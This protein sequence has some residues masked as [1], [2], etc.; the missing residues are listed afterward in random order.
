MSGNNVV[1]GRARAILSKLVCAVKAV[2]NTAFGA[3]KQVFS[4]KRCFRT[5][6]FSTAQS[7]FTQEQGIHRN[8]YNK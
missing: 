7:S 4:V 1:Y 2:N 3:E 8:R 6:S 5:E